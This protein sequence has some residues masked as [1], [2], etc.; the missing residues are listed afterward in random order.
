MFFLENINFV[1]ILIFVIFYNVLKSTIRNDDILKLVLV[2]G[3]F[4]I[5][6]LVTDVTSLAIL[7]VVSVLTFFGGYYLNKRPHTSSLFP[8]LT[9]ILIILFVVRNYNLH[10]VALVQ[11]VGLSYMLFR[12]IDFLI[13][14]K[15]KK[16]LN[17]DL[18]SFLNYVFFFP[19]FLAGPIDRYSNFNYWLKQSRDISRWNLVK[20]GIF[21]ISLGLLKKYL[22][23]AQ[24]FLYA[25][26]FSQFSE[27]LSWQQ[28]FVFSLVNYSFYILFDF[29]GYSD[30][31]IG[32]AYLIG[33][34]TPENFNWPY[35]SRN[36]SVFWKRWHITFS[37]FLF[38]FIFKPIV[39]GLSRFNTTTS[40]VFITSI[41]YIITFLI[42]GLWHGNATNFVYWGLWHACGLII[43]K[44]W[45]SYVDSRFVNRSGRWIRYTSHLL[46][47]LATF[48]FV[49]VGWFFFNY[50]SDSI[51]VISPTFFKSDSNNFSVKM[52][53]FGSQRGFQLKFKP[54]NNQDSVINIEYKTTRDVA[55]SRLSLQR[56]TDDL[57]Y[58]IPQHQVKNFERDLYLFR[59][60]SS[61]GGKN[62]E[63]VQI[64]YMALEN[65]NATYLQRTLFGVRSKKEINLPSD[66]RIN[67]EHDLHL[68]LSFQ[69]E[70]RPHFF[71]DYGWGVTITHAASPL[72]KVEIWL[73]AEDA[74]DWIIYQNDRPG[75]YGYAH[76]H[77]E[78]SAGGVNR[79]LN[80]GKFQVR[81]RYL[82]DSRKSQWFERSVL[83]PNYSK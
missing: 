37:R 43:Y 5:I 64:A 21:R 82:Y 11:R 19:T 7:I 50:N 15:E 68:P 34:K 79:N 45:D 75:E 16:I 56:Q 70:A 2:F 18:L 49:T 66:S 72:Y 73:K 54:T 67:F 30:I 61:P 4:L 80:P 71:E 25:V 26:D 10:G 28:G 62:D 53:S 65:E 35:F 76:I 58:V 36:I 48:L 31:A 63:K 14:S 24:L 13:E 40:R 69:I 60:R 29:S 46:S 51:A 9:F 42:C 52:I 83:I 41:G 23:A 17:Y 78:I 77:G 6:S 33:I 1:V 44:I 20:I 32:T 22:L 47:T 27:K 74:K 39:T 3:S 57:Y 81:L 38:Q 8:V 59:I 12:F 55:Y